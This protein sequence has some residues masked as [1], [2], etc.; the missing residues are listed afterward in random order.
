MNSSTYRFKSK[1]FNLFNR[2]SLLLKER[3]IYEAKKIRIIFKWG[4]QIIIYPLYFLIHTQ[5]I[6]QKRFK[7]ANYSLNVFYSNT[8]FYLEKILQKTKYFL[9]D[10]EKSENY[11][12][13]QEKL[14]NV[15][16]VK[17]NSVVSLVQGLAS[18]LTTRKLVLVIDNKIIDVLSENQKDYL[19]KYI[20]LQLD[21]HKSN[22]QYSEVHDLSLVNKFFTKQNFISFSTLVFYKLMLWM[23]RGSLAKNLDFF[24]ELSDISPNPDKLFKGVQD[25]IIKNDGKNKKKTFYFLV[26]KITQKWKGYL[27]DK[28]YRYFKRQRDQFSLKF[29]MHI[30]IYYFLNQLL[31][32]KYL[33][34]HLKQKKIKLYETKNND[35]LLFQN[36]VS[37]KP[38][39]LEDK[40]SKSYP[41]IDLSNNNF[42][43]EL[44]KDK[45]NYLNIN[46]IF[47]KSI[48]NQL[49][50]TIDNE[51]QVEFTTN[52]T[53]V[54]IESTKYIK[55][56]LIMILEVLDIVIYWIEELVMKIWK[57]IFK[58]L[59]H[60][61]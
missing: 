6:D 40:P 17:N 57:V 4:I 47:K 50:P 20:N 3:L 23:K 9:L 34:H 39:L 61:K 7:E 30:T 48:N 56:P 41:T 36:E 24:G 12:K 59:N 52:F 5:K 2:K 19:H 35:R 37:D 38:I 27:Q 11:F 60:K 8:D 26:G 18:D 28:N 42:I 10:F 25:S 21:N 49:I 16:T 29:F 51:K 45:V 44:H 31:S 55:H 33:K 54:E 15:A 53:E 22:S 43:Y 13:K 14:K 58:V 46:Q 32:S 1:L